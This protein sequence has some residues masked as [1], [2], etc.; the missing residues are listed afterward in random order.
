MIRSKLNFTVESTDSEAWSHLCWGD[1]LQK[2]MILLET[3][4]A[5]LLMHGANLETKKA[6]MARAVVEEMMHRQLEDADL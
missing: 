5:M 6:F 2:I 1:G 4:V 3:P